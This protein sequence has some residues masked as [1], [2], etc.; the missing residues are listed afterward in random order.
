MAAP[1]FF[2]LHSRSKAIVA[3]SRFETIMFFIQLP[4]LS[5][6]PDKSLETCDYFTAFAL[7]KFVIFTAD[8]AILQPGRACK[9]VFV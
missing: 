6:Y 5:G 7:G 2:S 3:I 4:F 8:G 9:F 1:V